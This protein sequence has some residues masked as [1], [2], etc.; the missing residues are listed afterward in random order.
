MSKTT[1]WQAA[2]GRAAGAAG[3]AARVG[4]GL[5]GALLVA[6]GLWLAWAP[7]GFVAGGTFLLLADRRMP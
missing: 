4:P 3:H 7:L 1:R 6:Y 2:V 5:A